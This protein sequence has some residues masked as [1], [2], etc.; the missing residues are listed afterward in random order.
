MS[1][2]TE[3]P[4]SQKLNKE[5]TRSFF[6]SLGDFPYLQIRACVFSV[7]AFTR[8]PLKNDG[9]AAYSL[10]MVLVQE[11]SY[12]F[13]GEMRIHV[14]FKSLNRVCIPMCLLIAHIES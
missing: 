8:T 5:S 13:W 10:D 14:I 6:Y 12:S 9:L 11:M 2:N 1:K 3:N 7:A 4:G